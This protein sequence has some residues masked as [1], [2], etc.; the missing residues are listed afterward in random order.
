MEN[1]SKHYIKIFE[2]IQEDLKKYIITTLEKNLNGNVKSDSFS[3]N[4]NEMNMSFTYPFGDE[5]LLFEV[6]FSDNVL[7]I[8]FSGGN[9]YYD[10]MED[11]G[12]VEIFTNI[13]NTFINNIKPR[14]EQDF[15]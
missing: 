14:L 7:E 13:K 9:K 15:T 12:V 4:N 8:M 10:L 11:N 5:I 2:N 3:I 1:K 6:S